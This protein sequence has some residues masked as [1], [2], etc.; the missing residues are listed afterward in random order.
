MIDCLIIESLS[1]GRFH[2]SHQMFPLFRKTKEL[3]CDRVGRPPA[4]VIIFFEELSEK[5]GAFRLD[6]D[7]HAKH[8]QTV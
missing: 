7:L 2:L 5:E 3:S 4:I 8:D 6:I 1:D